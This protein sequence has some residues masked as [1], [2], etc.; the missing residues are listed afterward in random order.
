M[1]GILLCIDVV[2]ILVCIVF[3][4]VRLVVFFLVLFGVVLVM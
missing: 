3:E 1:M 4:F 2:M